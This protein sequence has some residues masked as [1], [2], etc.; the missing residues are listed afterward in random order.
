MAEIVLDRVTKSYPDGAGGVRQAVKEFSM[1]IADGEFI[2]LV[3][4]SGCGKSTTLNMIAGLEDISSGELRIGGQR[5]NDKAPKDRDIA[6]VFQSYALYPHMTVRQ[7][8]AFPLTLAK[9]KKDQIAAKVEE[10]AK[11]LDLTELL[12]RKPAQLSGGQ[13]QRVAMGRAIVRSPK[14]F[15]MDEP[16]S[17]L[18]AKLRVQ[19]RAEIARLQS[20]LGTTTVYVTHDQTEAMTLGDRVVVLLAGEV[21]QI[22]TPDELY[23]NPANLF[24]AGFI[25]SPAMNFFPAT[26]TDVGVRLPFGEVTL[27][28]AVHDQ[29]ARHR[30]SKNIIV[31]IRPEHLEDA[32]LLDGYARIRALSFTVRADIVESLGA[33][34]YVHFT[35]EGAGAQAA[36]LAELAADS[37]AGENEFVARVSAESKVTAGQ[38]VELAFDTSKLVIFDADTGINLTRVVET[39]APAEAPVEDAEPAA[40]TPDADAQDTDSDDTATEKSGETT[41][42]E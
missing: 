17:N 28:Q 18:D 23:T 4:P 15:L 42:S 14:A 36:Q 40:E 32:S 9:L 34:K 3:G 22:G 24:V 31:G 29:L 39:E 27:T 37:G 26:F 41:D 8:I 25:G 35:T 2:I 30:Q 7:N 21:Q 20:R 38:Q 19:M 1:T 16:L 10:T 33:D 12:D 13:R 5:V 6:M 11:I